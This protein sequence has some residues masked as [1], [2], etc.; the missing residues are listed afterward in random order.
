MPVASCELLRLIQI[1][2][3]ETHLDA[4]S[5]GRE[6]LKFTMA[7][8]NATMPDDHDAIEEDD[9]DS[10]SDGVLFQHPTILMGNSNKSQGL[11]L[12]PPENLFCQQDAILE[13]FQLAVQSHDASNIENTPT[14]NAPEFFPRRQVQSETDSGDPFGIG[15]SSCGINST[16][17]EL[18]DW[19]PKELELPPWASDLQ[20]RSQPL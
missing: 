2:D 9:S 20:E 19:E 14:W 18:S 7:D 11:P 13:C 12:A 17:H 15:D 16:K 4:T 5:D 8:P 3:H 6:V 1:S 10:D